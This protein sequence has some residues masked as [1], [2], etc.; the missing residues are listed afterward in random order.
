MAA[1]GFDRLNKYLTFVLGE[2]EYGLEILRVKEIIGLMTITKVPKM[3]KYVRGVI[4]LRG[5]VIPVVDLRL[6]F[7]MA[8]IE[9]T[10]E[11]CI[12]V[13]DLGETLIGVVVDK[14]S[15]V[16]DIDDTQ[17]DEAPSFGA[18][19][20]TSFIYGIGKTKDKVVILLDIA[21][22]LVS[23]TAQLGELIQKRGEFS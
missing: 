4:N 18:H 19:V 17:I 20:D 15:E 10:K 11:T 16:L 22:A 9:D 1:G 3:P 8:S 2:E 12:I 6:K 13:V 7:G 23:E 14:V 5:V 21:K